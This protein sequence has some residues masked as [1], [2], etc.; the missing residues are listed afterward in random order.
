[1]RMT[2][3]SRSWPL[4]EPVQ[5]VSIEKAIHRYSR[6]CV[7][8]RSA[9]ATTKRSSWELRPCNSPCVKLPHTLQATG[10]VQERLANEASHSR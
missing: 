8:I 4:R 2:I 7:S 10:V 6:H 1:M 3:E 9:D 5:F